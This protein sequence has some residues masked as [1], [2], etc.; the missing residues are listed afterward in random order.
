MIAPAVGRAFVPVRV[1]DKKTIKQL[2]FLSSKVLPIAG[3]SS[4]PSCFAAGKAD[5]S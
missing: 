5:P 4:M 2:N 3:R 1:L